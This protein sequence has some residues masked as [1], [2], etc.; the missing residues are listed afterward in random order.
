M[1]LGVATPELL[2]AE[3]WLIHLSLSLEAHCLTRDA[4]TSSEWVCSLHRGSM[5]VTA[6]HRAFGWGTA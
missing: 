2:M 4:E 3:S 1:Q 6:L 5:E